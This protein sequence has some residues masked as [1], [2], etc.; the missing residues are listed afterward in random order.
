M[1]RIVAS[2]TVAVLAGLLASAPV[3]AESVFDAG[4]PQRPLPNLQPPSVSWSLGSGIGG[5]G[6]AVGFESAESRR[7]ISAGHAA[8]WSL[9]LPGL[10]QQRAGHTLRA[11]IFYGFEAATWISVA[12]FLWMGYEREKTYK[13]YAVVFAGVRGTDHS[14]DFYRTIGEYRASDGPG[15]YNEAV[16]RE[17][18]DLYYPN[19]EAIESY[20]DARAMTG[21]E[22]WAWRGDLEYRH[23]G[24]IRDGSRFAYRLALYSAIGAAALRI[25][26]AA[27]AVRIVHI[28]QRPAES[29][30]ATSI[31]IEGLPRGLALCVRRS[32]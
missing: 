11:K 4:R 20:Y 15:G 1:G 31:G 2:M 5:A 3:L 23:Y 7:G 18:R 12:S 22:S 21:N 32:F 30:G 14:N 29:G 10:G 27:D 19:V 16:R 8:A 13:D 25:V 24:D 26:S 9:L 28:D 17:A 6:G